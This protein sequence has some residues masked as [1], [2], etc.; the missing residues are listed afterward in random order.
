MEAVQ[1]WSG[2]Q[3]VGYTALKMLLLLLLLRLVL[4]L[5]LSQLCHP[6]CCCAAAAAFGPTPGLNG[7]TGWGTAAGKLASP[8]TNP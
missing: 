7:S 1:P 6:S 2:S 4:L 5:L 8:C 3:W